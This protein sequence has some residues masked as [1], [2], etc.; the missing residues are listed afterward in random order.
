MSNVA[1]LKSAPAKIEDLLS[2]QVEDKKKNN[3]TPEK[4]P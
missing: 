2:E 1:M 4:I 3:S